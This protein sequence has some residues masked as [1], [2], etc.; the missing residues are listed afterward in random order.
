MIFVGDDW[1]EAQ[2]DVT[3]LD[4][5]GKQCGHLSIADTVEGARRLQDFSPSMPTP[6]RRWSS[7]SRP[8]TGCSLSC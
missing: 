7:A 1:G 8:P 5:Q 3:V 6:R 2:H 4:E